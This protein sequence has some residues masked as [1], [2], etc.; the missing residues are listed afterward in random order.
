MTD[1]IKVEQ[2]VKWIEE[3]VDQGHVMM[4]NIEHSRPGI[5]SLPFD[6]TQLG[7]EF[8]EKFLKQKL[9]D[10]VLGRSRPTSGS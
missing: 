3:M 6:D 5:G 8:A 1:E 4:A 7:L 10:V 2:I 9:K